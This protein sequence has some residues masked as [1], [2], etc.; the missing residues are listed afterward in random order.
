MDYSSWSCFALLD[1]FTDKLL[2]I[3]ELIAIQYRKFY[4]THPFD[5]FRVK[6]VDT[7]HFEDEKQ[8]KEMWIYLGNRDLFETRREWHGSHMLSKVS[9]TIG[10]YEACC[11][12][13]T[14]S[15]PH[16]I[17]NQML[18]AALDDYLCKAIH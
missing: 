12:G 16:G 10:E 7:I 18:N 1:L 4:I 8:T 14:F 11:I 5:A 3:E 13:P 6:F 9:S 15:L 17:T 2:S